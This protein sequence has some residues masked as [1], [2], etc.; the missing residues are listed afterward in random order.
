MYYRI[1]DKQ[2]AVLCI[3]IAFALAFVSLMFGLIV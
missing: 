3:A 2:K 1:S